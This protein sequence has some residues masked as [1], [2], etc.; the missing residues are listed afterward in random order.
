MTEQEKVIKYIET[1]ILN[2]YKN[3]THKT[4]FQLEIETQELRT[5]LK[6]LFPLFSSATTTV[7][8]DNLSGKIRT[9]FNIEVPI[10]SKVYPVDLTEDN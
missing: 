3:N 10:C 4:Y 5:A 6:I 9:R 7:S 8:I 1:E 2:H